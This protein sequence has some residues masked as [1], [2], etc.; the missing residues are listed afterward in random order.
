MTLKP[1]NVASNKVLRRLL[2]R[3]SLSDLIAAIVEQ[4]AKDI[5]VTDTNGTLFLGEQSYITGSPSEIQ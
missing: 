2:R 3:K 5:A 1:E 4:K